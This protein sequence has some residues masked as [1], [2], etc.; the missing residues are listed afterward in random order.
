ME[1]LL[2]AAMLKR[3]RFKRGSKSVAARLLHRDIPTLP[4][5]LQQFR[6]TTLILSDLR[7]VLAG[8]SRPTQ[9][10]VKADKY[11]GSVPVQQWLDRGSRKY[12]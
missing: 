7:A 8:V 12:D 3:E 11:E 5:A 4:T 2:E 1:Y 10:E 6:R 9:A